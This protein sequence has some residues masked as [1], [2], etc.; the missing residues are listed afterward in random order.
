MKTGQVCWGMRDR[1]GVLG[2][3]DRTGVVGDE[4]R[5][6]VLWVQG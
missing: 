5:T 1:T 4:V 3:E 2:H 6:G